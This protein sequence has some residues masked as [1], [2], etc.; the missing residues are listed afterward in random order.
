M[1]SGQLRKKVRLQQPV[2]AQDNFGQELVT[3]PDVIVGLR[4]SIRHLSGRELWDARQVNA[5]INF[6][7]RLRWYPGVRPSWRIVDMETNRIYNIVTVEDVREREHE[8]DILA[9]E[10]NA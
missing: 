7:I 4:A 8:L 5:Q 2:T 9:A 10:Q 1:R 3:Y 6:H